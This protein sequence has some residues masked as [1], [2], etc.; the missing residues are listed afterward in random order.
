[1][2]KYLLSIDQGTTGTTALIVNKENLN[3]IT[4]ANFEYEQLYPKTGWVEHDLNTIW[5]T[6]ELATTQALQSANIGPD[7]ILA[8]GITNQ[9]ET[10]CA[11][12]INGE[13]LANAIVWQDRR[14]SKFCDENKSRY[15]SLKK[16]TGLPLDSYFSATKMRWL[17][18]NN[19]EVKKALDSN[20]L[21][22]STIDTYL[23]YKL[24]A[25][26]SFATEASNAS[27]T[28]LMDLATTNWSK[29][30]LNFFDIPLQCLPEIKDSFANFG[31]TKGLSFL[32]DGIPITCMLGDQ[33]AALFGQG[34]YQEGSLKCTYGTG[35]FILL[36][37]GNS[38]V[39]SQNGLLTTVA[40]RYQGKTFYALEGAAY[41]AGAAVQWLRDNLKIIAS[42]AEVE[43]LAN[44]I[45]N[46]QEMEEVF[47]F[48]FFT[49]IGTP[50]WNSNAKA[51]IIGLTRA[52][53]NA[54]IAMAC[55]EGISL[56]VNDSVTSLLKDSPKE[57]TSMNVDGGATM[58]DLLLS[59]QAN[60]SS[61]KIVRPTVIETTAYGVA[62]GA[63]IGLG[64]ITFKDIDNLWKKDKEFLPTSNDYYSKKLKAWNQLIPK[65]F[66]D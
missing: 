46:L 17:I 8:I 61:L 45:D 32:P 43:T 22:L 23:L 21:R 47:F 49:G 44:Q 27:R 31:S 53:N 4:K 6:I 58:N 25:G 9:R 7:E 28:L 38:K 57:V 33:Q 39:Y 3:V 20:D 36:N 59:M 55:L 34:G 64:A 60:F 1:M 56:S 2:K 50:Y 12:R 48:P 63:L 13:P 41:I 24:T 52:T 30:L 10:T 15:E 62:L 19:T 37:T 40:Y 29:D 35:A 66:I 5:K 14:T 26:I 11:Y 42:S 54:H 16:R 18:D 65:F 51:A